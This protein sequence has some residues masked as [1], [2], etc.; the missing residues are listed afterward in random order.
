MQVYQKYHESL[1]D[2]QL[3][4]VSAMGDFTDAFAPK[5]TASDDSTMFK[6]ILDVIAVGIGVASAGLWNIGKPCK[7]TRHYLP[8]AS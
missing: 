8:P 1:Q 4:I 7:P 3:S 2:A 6:V 5:L